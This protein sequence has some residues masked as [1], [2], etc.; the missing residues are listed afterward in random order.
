[1]PLEFE[2]LSSDAPKKTDLFGSLSK[3][4]KSL[5]SSSD[6]AVEPETPKD[7]SSGKPEVPIED[8]P[9]AAPPQEKSFFSSLL[10]RFKS[11]IP[12]QD[13]VRRQREWDA[14]HPRPAR[15]IDPFI[16]MPVTNKAIDIANNYVP[17]V[18][19]AATYGMAIPALLGTGIGLGS[20]FNKGMSR[21][22]S[23]L[24]GTL[25]DTLKGGIRGTLTAGGLGVGAVAG[26][27]LGNYLGAQVP[28]F[29]GPVPVDY[30]PPVVPKGTTV[31][32]PPTDTINYA[33]PIG[34]GLGIGAGG[35]IGYGAGHGLSNLLL[36]NDEEPKKEITKESGNKLMDKQAFKKGFLLRCAEEGLNIDQIK[37]RIKKAYQVKKAD[38]VFSTLG[39]WGKGLLDMGGAAAIGLPIATGAI[40]GYAYNKFKPKDDPELLKTEDLSNEYYRLADIARRKLLINK[41]KE[42]APG[43]LVRIV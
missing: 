33:A 16:E 2:D 36:G 43:S 1:M 10:D 22:G 37:D 28:G 31:T 21:K 32:M 9:A 29:K 41:M 30:I 15:E 5:T 35:A 14:A 39:G 6:K 38:G 34:A 4:W 8:V 20:G 19:T 25:A 18:N 7:T 13:S 3:G 11:T 12:V 26:G 24:T 27:L 42:K 40:G 17:D 23:G